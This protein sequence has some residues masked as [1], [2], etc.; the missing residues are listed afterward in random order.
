VTYVDPEG[1]YRLD[2]RIATG[3]MGV[4]WRGTDTV[5]NRQV[6]IKVLKPEF[7]DDPTFRSRFETEARHAAALHHPGVA[8]VFDFGEG[9]VEDGPRPFLVMELVD[10]QPLSE[11]LR[12]NAPMDPDAARELIALTADALG[13][14]HAAGIVH[15]D[16]K[17]ANLM[18]L[19]DRRVKITDFGIAR[20][21]DGLA[22]TMTGQVMG[23]PQYL[24][25]EQAEG[26]T[27]TPASDIYSLGVVAFECLAGYRPF[28]GET[29]VT[30]ALA[31]LREPVPDLPAFVPPDLAAVVRRAL[32][33][34]PAERFG[35]AAEFAAA[36]RSPGSMTRRPLP[37]P[38]TE[39]PTAVLGAV[40]PSAPTAVLGGVPPSAPPA[41]GR[42][43]RVGAWA[44]VLLALVA[45]AAVVAL[46]LTQNGSDQ[47]PTTPTDTTSAPT[48][49]TRD[50]SA[51][52]TP[53]K[54]TGVRIDAADYIGRDVDQVAQELRDLGLE[55]S[56]RRVDNPG[57]QEADTVENVSPDGDLNEGDR[58][59][60]TYWGAAPSSPPTSAPTSPPP[61]S[62]ATSTPPTPDTSTP[63][64][65]TTSPAAVTPSA[66]QTAAQTQNTSAGKTQPLTGDNGK[67][68]QR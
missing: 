48:R 32:A 10:G 2:S 64:A 38:V 13:A 5:L 16:V 57:D 50:T 41:A 52:S 37:P 39:A 55:V 28:V 22:L 44:W 60:V 46:L 11:L 26:G 19:P 12:P 59:T 62:P 43:R 58:V 29:P 6:A 17:P 51:P 24:S 31:H 3:G 53:T 61:T 15:R 54:D 30:T 7:A 14:A 8:A 23:T 66:G 33:K 9:T 67:A 34:D 36:L 56:T 4:V 63:A 1:R 27:A 45:V 65:A 47:S 40:P 35:S 49:P 25:P 42:R 21:A 20:A 18:V 68:S